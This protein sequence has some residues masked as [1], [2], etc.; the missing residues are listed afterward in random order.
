[1][2][3][4]VLRN[5]NDTSNQIDFCFSNLVHIREN[6][7]MIWLRYEIGYGYVF[8]LLRDSQMLECYSDQKTTTYFTILN[9][10]QEHRISDLWRKG[11]GNL[12]GCGW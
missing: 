7:E 8:Q 12:G 10:I 9:A 3:G 2:V 5:F 6:E 4:N 1:M 11:K